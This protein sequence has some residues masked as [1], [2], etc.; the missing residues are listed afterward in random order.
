MGSPSASATARG[1]RGRGHVIRRGTAGGR[2]EG[3]SRVVGR[4]VASG[5]QALEGAR[6]GG[7]DVVARGAGERQGG[8]AEDR[9]ALPPQRG[10][11]AGIVRVPG[12]RSESL[13]RGLRD[14]VVHIVGHPAERRGV[15]EHGC[16]LDR[17]AADLPLA[18]REELREAGSGLR[19]TQAGE[20]DEPVRRG[21]PGDASARTA[22]RG[23]R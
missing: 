6:R 14:I 19:G 8:G 1:G 7:G 22:R 17:V 12:A 5:H 23:G 15:L 18:V 9:G 11:V 3:E 4:G 10:E 2:E 16:R 13:D 20:G 21:V